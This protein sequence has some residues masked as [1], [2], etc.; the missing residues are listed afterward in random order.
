MHSSP[1]A[2]AEANAL[3]LDSFAEVPTPRS[4]LDELFAFFP[5]PQIAKVDRTVTVAPSP[6]AASTPALRLKVANP[7]MARRPRQVSSHQ[8]GPGFG[9]A[10]VVLLNPVE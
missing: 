4:G 5:C 9:I 2:P 7:A 8:L 6:W 1:K 10:A 3:S